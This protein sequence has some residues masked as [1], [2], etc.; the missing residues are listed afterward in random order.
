MANVISLKDS[1]GSAESDSRLNKEQH[2]AK[3]KVELEMTAEHWLGVLCAINGWNQLK[4]FDPFSEDK[5][6]YDYTPIHR[7]IYDAIKPQMDRIFNS[8]SNSVDGD[9]GAV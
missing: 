6:P 2:Q 1:V 9:S 4:P 8:A 7:Q 5:K 3:I